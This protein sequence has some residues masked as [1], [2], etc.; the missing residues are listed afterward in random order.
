MNSIN[1]FYCLI[2][3]LLLFF[4]SYEIVDTC[5]KGMRK[6]YVDDISM[7]EFGSARKIFGAVCFFNFPGSLFFS[8]KVLIEPRFEVH[9]KVSTNPIEIVEKERE[10]NIY[11]FTIVISGYKN[12]ISGLDA[13]S[14]EGDVDDLVFEDI[15]YNNFVNSLIIEFDF[16]KDTYDPDSSSFSIRFCEKECQTSSDRYAFY[17]AK[18]N[19]QRYDPT[20]VNNWDFRFI[21]KNNKIDLYSGQNE[22]IFSKSISLED[23]LGTNIAYVGFTGFMESNRR[24]ISLIGTFI[25]E[26]NYEI[27][28]MP[29]NFL[30]NNNLYETATYEAGS[31]LY[32]IFSFINNQGISVPHTYGYDIWNYTF[33]LV[34]DCGFNSLEISKETNY[35]LVFNMKACTKAGK[36]SIYIKEKVKGISPYRYY[37]VNPG[38]V[39]KCI[40][41]GHDGKIGTVPLKYLYSYKYLSFGDSPNGDFII[42]DKFILILDFKMYDQYENSVV[43][44]KKSPFTL[45]RISDNEEPSPLINEILKDNIQKVDTHYQL[46]VE[47]NEKGTYQLEANGYMDAIR[48]IAI[49][50]EVNTINLNTLN[51]EESIKV[52]N[53]KTENYLKTNEFIDSTEVISQTSKVISQTSKESIENTEE[54]DYFTGDINQ[55][56]N[57]NTDNADK[58]DGMNPETNEFMDK[59]EVISQTTKE[60]IEKTDE[61]DY[62]TTDTNQIS[63]Y[64]TAD[65]N[66]ISN[67]NTDDMNSATNEL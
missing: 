16:V 26:D 35:T 54:K 55:I 22:I 48:F 43:E 24:E 14:F 57:N 7:R 34:S 37:T 40:L 15:G 30:I 10:Q 21:Y 49:K 64:L 58:T 66:Q 17:S 61:K 3:L 27:S 62:L 2:I 52:E 9:L 33:S 42:K 56:S 45:K 19:S 12:T 59:T 13:R 29:G 50:E 6:T 18:L 28:K 47:I 46:L 44:L 67:N 36:H 41:I 11:G 60:N 25:C 53:E 8:R 32:Y 5:P 20:K 23:S 39:K 38:P 65:T 1:Y 4:C 63:N 31:Y 51:I